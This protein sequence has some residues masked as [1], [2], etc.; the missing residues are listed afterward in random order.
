MEMREQDFQ[1]IM[2][3]SGDGQMSPNNIED[4]DRDKRME[5]SNI[6]KSNINKLMEEIVQIQ[7]DIQILRYILTNLVD[8]GSQE[9]NED[10]EKKAIKD[11]AEIR[12]IV[13]NIYKILKDEEKKEEEIESKD[14]K[15]NIV[16]RKVNSQITFRELQKM[17]QTL[18]SEM[19]FKTTEI[20]MGDTSARRKDIKKKEIAKDSQTTTSVEMKDKSTGDKEKKGGFGFLFK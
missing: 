10:G 17:G 20:V 11:I 15:E 2:Q 5:K 19:S 9:G 8:S 7:N 1:K 3:S 6:D 18:P 12:E 4:G 16:P 14:E 13:A